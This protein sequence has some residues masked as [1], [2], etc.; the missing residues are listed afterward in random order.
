M[1]APPE[2]IPVLRFS[3]DELPE[4]D[5]LAM[6][7]E[8]FG[9]IIR[10]ELEPVTGNDFRVTST[11][12]TLPGI[13]MWS[14]TYSSPVRLRRTPELLSDG[15]DDI[16]LCT[17]PQGHILFARFGEEPNVR[18][19]HLG[20]FGEAYSVTTSSLCAIVGVILPRKPLA[21]MVRVLDDALARPISA[22][23]AAMNLLTKY[24]HLLDEQERLAT[25][26]LA[27]L[28]VNHVY[29]LV[30]LVLGATGDAAA[31]ANGRG[32]RAARLRAIKAE[33]LNSLNRPE[34]SLAGLAAR[35]ASPRGTCRCCSRAMERRSHGSCSTS[36]W[37]AH[38]AC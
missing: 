2:D 5:R 20:S 38:I 24:V 35:H 12:R 29:D 7:R 14:S 32:V 3:T 19:R 11:L 15:N 4:R 9:R 25:P 10:H 36:V 27:R 17:V 16:G 26:E 34:L 23:S 22:D 18:A 21:G 28:V 6:T 31:M 37:C 33:I 13:S 30:A 1:T 8:V